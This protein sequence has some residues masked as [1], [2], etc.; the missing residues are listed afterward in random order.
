[1]LSVS[2]EF[3]SSGFESEMGEAICERREI[4]SRQGVRSLGGKIAGPN[5]TTSIY[6]A[7]AFLEKKYFL[8]KN[9]FLPCKKALAYYSAGAVAVNL[10]V[11]RLA[12]GLL[13]TTDL[14]CIVCVLE[15]KEMKKGICQTIFLKKNPTRGSTS[16]RIT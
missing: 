13:C 1:M 12:P 15:K 11:V 16:H 4:D 8:F 5:P 10:K 7:G 3:P 6:N 2:W 14:K 9:I